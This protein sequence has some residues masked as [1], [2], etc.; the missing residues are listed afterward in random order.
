MNVPN[1]PKRIL[2]VEDDELLRKALVEEFKAAGYETLEAANGRDGLVVALKE[3][4]DIILL[5]Q[6]M[7]VMTGIE[8]LKQLRSGDWGMGV[9]VIMGTNMTTDDTINE[10]IDAGANDYFIKAETT[11]VDILQTVNDRLKAA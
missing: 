8:M 5:D 7:P 4:P 2:F 9:P 1:P 10:A 6:V 3:R 11:V